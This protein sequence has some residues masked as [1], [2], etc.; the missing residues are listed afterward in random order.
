MTTLRLPRPYSRHEVVPPSTIDSSSDLPMSSLSPSPSPSPFPSASTSTIPAT[1]TSP[2]TLEA[3]L[4]ASARQQQLKLHARLKR[5]EHKSPFVPKKHQQAG[6]IASVSHK[7][8][9]KDLSDLLEHELAEMLRVNASLLESK[10]T[11]SLLPGSSDSK[12]RQ[13]QDRLEARLKEVQDINRIR[14]DLQKTRLEG[15]EDHDDDTLL[16]IDDDQVTGAAGAKA[17]EDIKPRIGAGRVG[18]PS[19]SP[20][21]PTAIGFSPLTVKRRLALRA[22]VKQA[23]TRER[24]A[25]ERRLQES[26]RKDEMRNQKVGHSLKGAFLKGD[27][28]EPDEE[29]DDDDPL[30]DAQ[31]EMLKIQQGQ[32][33]EEEDRELNPYSHAYHMGR[34]RTIAEE[35]GLAKGADVDADPIIDVGMQL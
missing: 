4:A 27:D 14:E 10:S 7:G 22:E 18:D 29:D 13:Q 8:K 31:E 28:D 24:L 21:H 5:A 9:E 30:L 3:R 15:N 34:S 1:A 6:G 25:T 20:A 32:L 16:D 11:M 33:D 17:E 19:S 35:K 2:T 26:K 12:I 23:A